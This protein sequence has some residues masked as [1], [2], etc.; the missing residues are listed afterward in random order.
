MAATQ[1]PLK[2]RAFIKKALLNK[3]LF[4]G[5]CHFK[6]TFHPHVAVSS[7]DG[8]F[9]PIVIKPSDKI[10]KILKSKFVIAFQ[11]KARNFHVFDFPTPKDTICDLNLSLFKPFVDPVLFFTFNFFFT[12]TLC[13]FHRTLGGGFAF[14]SF[15]K[16]SAEILFHGG[17]PFFCGESFPR[18]LMKHLY[19]LLGISSTS[20]FNKF[21]FNEKCL[22]FFWKG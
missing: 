12:E 11:Q 9:N 16:E 6:P 20:F 19:I 22:S 4:G 17:L 10:G 2:K 7:M 1:Y 5:D 21:F 14:Q 3:V 18:H 13:F 8:H 15:K